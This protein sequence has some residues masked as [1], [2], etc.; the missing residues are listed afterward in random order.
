MRALNVFLLLLVCSASVKS[1][2]QEEVFKSLFQDIDKRLAYMEDVA[3][4]KAR[5]QLAIENQAREVVVIER[6]KL[7]AAEHGLLPESV[8]GFFK[9]QII[10]AKAIQYRHRANLL[11]QPQAAN[12]V[13]LNDE[14]RPELIRLGDRIIARLGQLALVDGLFEKASFTMFES[15]IGSPYVTAQEKR[16]LFDAL[17]KVRREQ[18]AP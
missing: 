14:I 5:H 4:Y 18:G 17:R 3:S 10:V 15:M 16:L 1:S 9:A 8:D 13:S 7:A 2:P 6:A 12:T 11:S